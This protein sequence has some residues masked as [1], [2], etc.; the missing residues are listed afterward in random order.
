[1]VRA[2]QACNL[3][4]RSRRSHSLIQKLT[5]KLNFWTLASR[6]PVSYTFY[7]TDNRIRFPQAKLWSAIW[8]GKNELWMRLNKL[9][10]GMNIW[11]PT[12]LTWLGYLALQ[13]SNR[14][15]NLASMLTVK[16][17]GMRKRHN[18]NARGILPILTKSDLDERKGELEV[19]TWSYNFQDVLE[20]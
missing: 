3:T 13:E 15:G 19:A 9:L 6:W 16:G 12:F 8:A 18:A 20:P 5:E 10:R 1:M 17:H 11:L 2:R 4:Y 14:S 7:D